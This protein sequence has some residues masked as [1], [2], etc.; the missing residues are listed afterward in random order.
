MDK[1]ILSF[2][3]GRVKEAAQ[4]QIKNYTLDETINCRSDGNVIF[5]RERTREREFLGDEKNMGI[6][7]ISSNRAILA[8]AQMERGRR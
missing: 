6:G 2:F 3:P 4:R 1:S 7:R 8:R 5:F